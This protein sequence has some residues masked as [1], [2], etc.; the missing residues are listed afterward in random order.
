MNRGT[1]PVG[2]SDAVGL[3]LSETVVSDDDLT[4]VR[5]AHANMDH[6]GEASISDL[7]MPVFGEAEQLL[8]ADARDRFEFEQRSAGTLH[9]KSALFLTLT[10]VFAAF[11]T[12][13]VARLLDKG[14]RTILEDASLVVFGICLGV[15]TL[16]ALLVGRSTISR[17]YQI[18]AGPTR[19]ANHLTRLRE[20][21]ASCNAPAERVFAHLRLDL[22]DAWSEATEQC[23][24][25]NE[26]KAKTLE[27]VL[28][29]LT[30]SVPLSFVGFMLL[31]LR[32][33]LFK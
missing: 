19:W 14:N 9:N 30:M 22:L 7:P 28:L 27:R 10:G 24:R 23:E 8:L 2:R 33:L 1:Y 5:N 32:G 25:A 3:D 31:L 15:L 18:I 16:A 20:A 13:F 29:L 21:Y 6:N 11:L 4:H 12:Q 26:A 17:K